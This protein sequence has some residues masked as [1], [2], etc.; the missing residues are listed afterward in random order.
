MQHEL[1]CVCSTESSDRHQIQNP[2]LSRQSKK[3]DFEMWTNGL[4]VSPTAK[5]RFIRFLFQLLS[6]SHLRKQN[7]PEHH[8]ASVGLLPMVQ[9]G[10]ICSPGKQQTQSSKQV[11]PRS[12]HFQRSHV[13]CGPG[14]AGARRAVCGH[15]SASCDELTLSIKAA[16]HF[17]QLQNLP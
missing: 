7:S 13:T 11:S 3:K 5:Q 10:A 4:M 9:P 8:S 14:S 15:D 12:L 17:F 1:V 6:K 2:E 16:L